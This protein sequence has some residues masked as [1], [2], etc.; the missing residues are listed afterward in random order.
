MSFL[1]PLFLALGIAAAVPLLLHLMR[2]RAGARV[3]FPAVRYL[4]RAEQE[5]SRRLRLRNLLLMLLRVLLVLLIALAAARPVG[6]LAGTG[7]PATAL[8]I[9]LDN[10]LSSAAA[11]G[12][13]PVLAE[14]AGAARAALARAT[15]EDRLWLVTADGHVT[16]GTADALL[17][18]VDSTRPLAGAG[19]LPAALARAAALVQAAGLPARQLLL[20]TDAQGTA[21]QEVPTLPRVPVDAFV[22]AGPVPPNHAVIAAAAR[23]VR[24]TP[25]G[26]IVAR[27][28]GAD[29]TTYAVALLRDGA[30]PQTIARGT[31]RAGEEI[32]VHTTPSVRGW[33]GGFVALPPDELRG[34]DRRH[35][36]FWS[37]EPPAVRVDAS[38]GTFVAPA[39]DALVQSDRARR[40]AAIVVAAADV[41]DRL[42]ALLLPPADPV[43]VGAANRNLERLG[44][45]W[46]FGTL[47]RGGA[48]VRGERLE[49]VTA[50]QR[51]T[52]QPAAGAVADT[53]ATAG[54]DAWAVAGDG[55]VLLASPLAPTATS[56]PVRAAFVPWLADVLAQRLAADPGVVLEA[57][58]GALVHAP[59][60]VTAWAPAAGGPQQ[61]VVE[62]ALTAPTESG[63]YFLFRGPARAGAL[64]VNPEPEESVLDRLSPSVLRSRLGVRDAQVHASRDAFAAAAFD[65]AAGRSLLAPL[66]AG[67]LLVMAMEGWTARRG[68]AGRG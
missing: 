45:P 68:A 26:T 36:A 49:G 42:P 46:R 2:R 12:G 61:L 52:L 56:L 63:V 16:G 5:N 40:G 9:V 1:E 67:A 27:V 14:L 17:A 20:L 34:D 13:E 47:R 59:E 65:P 21:W 51:Y 48:D 19:D 30:E 57:A 60:W 44:V 23:P 41:A 58:P 62:G 37:G 66:L 28:A 11:A 10:S 6:R 31:A 54:G 18:V 4:V 22:P 15:A 50:S 43:R 32:V 25:G 3:E 39:L 55:F 64:V 7:H 29:S 38:A 8:A 35:L 24:F 53:L 33:T